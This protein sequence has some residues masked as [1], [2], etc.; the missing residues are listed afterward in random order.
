[1]GVESRRP[2]QLNIVGSVIP[3]AGPVSEHS[4]FSS[5]ERA[6]RGSARV[7]RSERS[8]GGTG[9][10]ALLTETLTLSDGWQRL[11][12][13][14]GEHAD[15]G[16]SAS[17]PDP[18]DPR[19]QAVDVPNNYG[20][21]DGLSEQFGPVSYRCVL[22][23][24]SAERVRIEF[25]A[26]DYLCDVWLDGVHLGEH[27][28][29]FAPF[30]FDI[31]D[32]AREGSEL[33]VRVVDP[34]EDLAP[35]APFPRHAK[36]VIKGTLKY[37][38]SRPGGLPGMHTPG[39]T[40][41]EGQSMTTGGITAPI[42]LH[43]TGPVR[44]E[45]VFITPLDVFAGK[46]HVAVVVSNGRLEPVPTRLDLC[47]RAPNGEMQDGSIELLADPGASRVD[48]EVTV[49]SP[50]P[51]W[52]S[53]HTDLG[54]PALY[55][56]E[57]RAVA[58]DG[59]TDL[60]RERFGFRTAAVVGEPKRFRLNERDVFIQAA[61]YI[62]RQHF[63][64]VDREFYRRDFRLCADAHLNS[65]GIHGHIQCRACYEAADE[66]GVLVFQD[67][68]L[69]W[70]YD[71]GIET[72]PGFIDIA[73]RQISDMA[74]TL[75]NHPS[76][77]YW[78]CHNEPTAM[79]VPGLDADPKHDPDNQILDEALEVALR[80]VDGVRHVHRAS[81]IG[82]DMHLY[83][84]SLLGGDVYGVRDRESWFVSEYG[85]WTLGPNIVRY[86]DAQDW[87]PDDAQMRRWLSRLSFGPSTLV[88]SG[89][90][91]R[92]ESSDA[93]RRATE[94][95]GAFLA[96][97]QTEWIRAH[98]A[99]PF[100]AYR[101]HF[102]CDWWGWAGGGL[103]DVDRQAK[104]TYDALKSASRPVLVC[105]TFPHSVFLPSER[106]D[107]PLCAVNETRETIDLNVNWRWRSAHASLVIGADADVTQHYNVPGA[108]PKSMVAMPAPPSADD[109][110]PSQRLL[111]SG[112]LTARIAP[113][114][115]VEIARLILTTPAG[116]LDSARLD[117]EWGDGQTNCHQVIAAPKGWFVGAGAFVVDRRGSR[118]L[119]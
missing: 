32:A 49:A 44:I 24:Y 82:D 52:P 113:E 71:A 84:G 68:P 27:E 40:A 22:P 65:V 104:A 87:P 75:Y 60:R 77:V 85:F 117:L 93:W 81:G 35:A 51:W 3:G 25:E 91:E 17:F 16:D 19:W 41:R 88:Y 90:P 110:P 38:D 5:V 57:V 54:E 67:F 70:H 119:L 114:S 99:A 62:P 8:G 96:K 63:A 31:S 116:E 107:I 26:V 103:L 59:I 1:M 58:P 33:I 112:T 73:T 56:L 53:S 94:A 23:E 83:D 105:A 102:F 18:D 80:A 39:W 6:V 66:E 28:G 64:D 11:V 118:R 76:V 14:E 30:G 43:G 100:H 69:Q 47:L 15:R 20:L 106:L 111:A 95:Y 78:A 48:F 92:Y 79:F 46:A 10:N 98:R 109:E 86:G 21:E 101:W 37:H 42:R 12:C 55:E 29:Y 34:F 2:M 50:E 36:R 72:N 74:Y 13:D 97:Y 9:S 7:V 61:N 4:L 89:L 115:A 108:T 45:A